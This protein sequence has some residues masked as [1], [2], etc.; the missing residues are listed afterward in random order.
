MDFLFQDDGS[1]I[2]RQE[3]IQ[4][5]AAIFNEYMKPDIATPI[6]KLAQTCYGDI[7]DDGVSGTPCQQQSSPG[8]PGLGNPDSDG[9]EGG[10]FDAGFEDFEGNNSENEGGDNSEVVDCLAEQ[11]EESEIDAVAQAVADEIRNLNTPT[12]NP[13]NNEYGALV[14]RLSNGT[15]VAAFPTEGNGG[16][17]SLNAMLADAQAEFGSQ[18]SVANVVGF[19]HLHISETGP[20]FNEVDLGSLSAL[21]YGNTMPSHPNIGSQTN[22]ITGEQIPTD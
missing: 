7:V 22:P 20:G 18:V 2:I 12:D 19:V 4:P 13:S 21:D 15:I 9:P 3:L 17:V 1:E 16:S 11:N 6:I 5:Q 10:E 8:G 14:I